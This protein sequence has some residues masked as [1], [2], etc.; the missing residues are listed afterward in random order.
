MRLTCTVKAN[1]HH[2]P[3]LEAQPS[4]TYPLGPTT[5]PAQVPESQSL[6]GKPFETR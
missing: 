6:T 2:R 3:L 1:E 5:D 4:T